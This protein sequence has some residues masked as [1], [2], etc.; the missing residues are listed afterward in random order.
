M[1]SRIV[2]KSQWAWALYFAINDLF[3]NAELI[4]FILPKLEG[5]LNGVPRLKKLKFFF[6]YCFKLLAFGLHV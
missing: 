2:Y 1:E 3:K 4:V 5:R 6:I